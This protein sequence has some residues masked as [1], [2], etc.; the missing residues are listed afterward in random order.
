MIDHLPPPESNEVL[1]CVYSV[2]E[3]AFADAWVVL[4][5]TALVA[6]I[7]LHPGATPEELQT[8]RERAAQDMK[9]AL[10]R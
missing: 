3:T 9:N 7:K 4:G 1:T 6:R 2:G 5:D 8:A 10:R